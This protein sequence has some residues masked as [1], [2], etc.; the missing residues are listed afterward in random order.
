MSQENVEVV[1]GVVEAAMRR[2]WDAA[3][4]AYDEG[5]VLDQTRLPD[6]GVYHGHE[7]VRAF[8]GQWFGAWNDLEIEPERMIDRGDQVIV[9][10]RFR[11]TGKGSGA[12]VAMRAADIWTVKRGK[13]VR[14]VG[15]PAASEALEAAGL[16]K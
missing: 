4:A 2:D 10:L 16:Q 13:V 15:Y 8:F 6:G 5:V 7:G 9:I 1:K 11:G 3:M 14:L 12:N